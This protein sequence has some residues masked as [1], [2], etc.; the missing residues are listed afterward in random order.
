MFG[1]ASAIRSATQGRAL[2][3]TEFAG[4]E[5]LPIDLQAK[6]TTEIR[7]R[8]GLKVDPPTADYYSSA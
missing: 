5:K 8:K 7:T 1:F 4:F 2:W 3:T 6:I